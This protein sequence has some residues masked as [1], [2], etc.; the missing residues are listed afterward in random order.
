M[1]GP[2]TAPAE[3]G[4]RANSFAVFIA[5]LATQVL[6]AAAG[7][8][9]PV[10]APIAAPTLGFEPYLVGLF[11]S[12]MYASAASVGLVSGA[13]VVRWG[14]VRVSQL[15]LLVAAAGLAV[16]TLGSLWALLLAALLLGLGYGPATP[17]SSHLLA[18]VTPAHRLNLVFSL[19]QTGVPLGYT[20]AG[21]VLP[22]TALAIGWRP[23][24]LALGLACLAI[25]A[26]LQP[27]RAGLD[28][29]ARPV[30]ILAAL[31]RPFAPLMLVLRIPPL[32]IFALTSFAFSG[33]QICVGTF[34]VTYL[35]DRIAFSPVAAGFVLSCAQAAG[36]G[37][38][39]LWGALADRLGRPR[40]LLAFLGFMMTAAALLVGAFTPAWPY[41]AIVLVAILFGGTA[42]AWNGIHLA[43]LARLAPPGR[44]AEVTGG[45]FFITFGGVTIV[46][47]AFSFLLH[48][49]GSYALAYAAV[50]VLT[51]ASGV[52][53]I[54]SGLRAARGDDNRRSA[55]R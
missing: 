45:T 44:A 43:Q 11:V 17:A 33:M 1:G 23:T 27:M 39:I 48:V 3:A 9:A 30:S 21:A 25:A 46:P 54:A 36:V 52:A 5:M 6:I 29:D 55:N 47:L 37:G 38:R 22:S 4:D 7:L 16:A 35:V 26:M 8:A 13:I 42:V 20:L 19:K 31:R 15:C 10:L 53:F 41:A 49:T 14:A 2:E 28:A 12:A 50:G 18:R 32:R 34:L 40:L 24:A 51:L